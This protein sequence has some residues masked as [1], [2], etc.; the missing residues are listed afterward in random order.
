MTYTKEIYFTLNFCVSEIVN[1]FKNDHFRNIYDIHIIL[2]LFSVFKSCFDVQK[3]NNT[4]IDG[5]YP[6]Q[7]GYPTCNQT[8]QI[9]CAGMNTSQPREYLTLKA[10]P[11][12]NFSK[13]TYVNS[14]VQN[15]K[16]SSETQFTKVPYMKFMYLLYSFAVM[17]F[18]LSIVSTFCNL[19]PS[20]MHTEASVVIKFTILKIMS[21]MSI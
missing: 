5:E 2:F 8:V 15:R 14:A 6:L 16:D 7:I 21:S 18:F 12:N 9:Y 1:T 20:P 19:V 11:G 3:Y 17:A 4:V 10:G 13:K